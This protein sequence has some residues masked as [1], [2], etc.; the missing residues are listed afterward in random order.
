MLWIILIVLVVVIARLVIIVS[1]QSSEFTVSRS[2]SI[3][4][5]A[6][7]VFPLVN[8]LHQWEHWSPWAK[9]DPNM[10][11]SYEGAPAGVGA[12]YNWTGKKTGAGRMTIRESRPNQLVKIQLDFLKPF[13]ATNTA[14]F[15]FQPDGNQTAVT[16]SMYGKKNF[17]A[18][19]MHLVVSMD[20]IVGGQFA[21]GLAQIKSL[22]EANS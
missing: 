4:A 19:A 21:E 12:I 9:M 18:K 14:E 8:D 20:T 5:P 10:Q 13:R 1:V 3:A 11:Q 16:W 17:I 15:T 22:A 6:T 7:S 2:T